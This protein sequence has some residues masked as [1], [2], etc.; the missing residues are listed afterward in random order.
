MRIRA[1][2]MTPYAAAIK[3]APFRQRRANSAASV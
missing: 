2:A 1:F 3:N